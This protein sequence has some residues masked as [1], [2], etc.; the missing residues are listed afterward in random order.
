MEKYSKVKLIGEGS[1]G[2]AYLVKDKQSHKQY[3]IKVIQLYH[4]LNF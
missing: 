3:V 2:K 1:F 4:A